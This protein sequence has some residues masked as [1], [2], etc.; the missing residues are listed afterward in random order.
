MSLM[1]ESEDPKR[2]NFSMGVPRVTFGGIR[3]GHPPHD[4]DGLSWGTAVVF[5]HNDEPRLLSELEDEQLEEDHWQSVEDEARTN[6][7]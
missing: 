4:P 5:R 1:L 6:F 3:D 7:L 2:N